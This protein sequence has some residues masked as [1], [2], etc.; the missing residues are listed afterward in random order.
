[1]TKKLKKILVT[2]GAGF[3]GSHVVDRYIQEG[4]E[5]VIIDDLSTGRR[6]NINPQAKFYEMDIRSPDIRRV[7]E[8][9]KPD[10]LNH[11]AAQMSVRVSVKEPQR[12]ADINI[13]GSLNLLELAHEFE[14]KKVIYISTGGAVYGE[15]E[16]LPC[17]EAHPVNPICQYGASKHTVEHYLYMY[18]QIYGLNYTVLRYPNVYGPRQDPEG[19]AGVVAIFTGQMLAGLP[20]TING[21]GDQ[22]RDFVYVADC[23]E[24]NMLVTELQEVSGIY[25]LGSGK[26]TSVNQIFQTLREVTEYQREALRAPAKLGETYKIYLDPSKAR[27]DLEWQAEVNLKAGLQRTVDFFKNQKTQTIP[28]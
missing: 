9:E 20:V 25:N 15:P 8:M 4:Y 2:G 11:H 10:I 22:V 21:D 3:I 14:L 5:V 17:D 13:I 24:A 7:F 18:K 16:Y 1:M 23:V 12:D 26:G 28:A 19:E 6:S 27:K